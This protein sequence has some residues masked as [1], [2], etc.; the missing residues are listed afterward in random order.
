VAGPAARVLRLAA[1]LD[2]HRSEAFTL[3]GLTTDVPGYSAAPRDERGDVVQS[4]PGWEA[5]RKQLRRDLADLSEHFGIEVVYDEPTKRYRLAPPFLTKE[6][7]RALLAA[8][9]VVDVEGIPDARAGELGGGVGD[10]HRR[11]VLWVHARVV[12]FLDARRTGTPVA[13]RYRGEDRTLDPYAIGVWRNTWYVAGWEHAVD[14]VRV[15]R[16]ER[17]EEDPA[18]ASPPVREA[19]EAKSFEV[20]AD[21]S[22][23]DVL[24]LDPNDWGDDP[25]LVAR[26]RVTRDRLGGF[27]RELGGQVVEESDDAAIVELTVRHYASFRVRLTAFDGDACLLGPPELVDDVV[28]WLRAI[29]ERA[30]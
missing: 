9:A 29:A 23:G 8:A 3:G 1:Y 7:R 17:I 19:G 24:R 14:G 11:A 18:S 25:P 27:Q 5:L 15:F 13:F 4:T 16:L 2:K 21:F 28:A 12:D 22:P 20:P 30:N 26:V 10:E 6:E